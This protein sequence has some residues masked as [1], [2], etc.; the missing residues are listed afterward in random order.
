MGL[1][2]MVANLGDELA[3]KNLLIFELKR[4]VEEENKKSEFILK[5]KLTLETDLAKF[6][7]VVGNLKHEL[8]V[9]GEEKSRFIWA[10]LAVFFET[11]DYEAKIPT[12][13]YYLKEQ[14]SHLYKTVKE[15][16]K[17]TYYQ[18]RTLRQG[19]NPFY[20]SLSK[21]GFNPML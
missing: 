2:K 18:E 11:L 16:K 12:S 7:Q 10:V 4:I 8:Q 6:D 13:L 5:E 19:P 15:K 17:R 20:K 9:K 14:S 1:E 21:L 3:S